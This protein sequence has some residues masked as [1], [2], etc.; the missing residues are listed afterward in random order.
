M[1][2]VNVGAELERRNR[3]DR[4][5]PLTDDVLP[6]DH[7]EQSPSGAFD[8][9]WAE[10]IT[11]AA[12]ELMRQKAHG[13]RRAQWRL[14]VLGHRYVDD[15]SCCR[16]P[17]ALRPARAVRLRPRVGVPAESMGCSRHRR[18]TCTHAGPALRTPLVLNGHFDQ[19]LA[20]ARA[21]TKRASD[22]VVAYEV[23]GWTAHIQGEVTE[24]AGALRRACELMPGNPRLHQELASALA[25][26][27]DID[28][29]RA[30]AVT[31]EQLAA[32]SGGVHGWTAADAVLTTALQLTANPTS[33]AKKDGWPD[34]I[35]GTAN[36]FAGHEL[37]AAE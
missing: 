7:R 22:K 11:D 13:D 28:G 15:M 34:L 5:S 6:T 29:A 14:Q 27:G 30:A 3:R 24:G 17:A 8:R 16:G 36:Y 23:L 2:V 18:R 31:A 37:R 20:V 1:G 26:L 10:M 19:A 32:Q 33:L 4:T 9:V 25:D 21:N 35:R 12:W